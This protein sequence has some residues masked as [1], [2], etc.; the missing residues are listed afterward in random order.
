MNLPLIT[1]I[2]LLIAAAIAIVIL[3]L[4]LNKL[5]S[6]HR[7]LS[8]EHAEMKDRFR[9]IVDADAE[10][11]RVLDEA[12]ARK[13]GLQAELDAIKER[14]LGK[15]E[16]E[17]TQ[18]L[19]DIYSARETHGQVLQDLQEQQ[20]RGEIELEAIRARAREAENQALHDLKEKQAHGQ[21]ELRTL[22]ASIKQLRKE[23]EALDEEANLQSFGFYKPRYDFAASNQY[24]SKLDDIRDLQ[25]R[26]IK[27]KSA[28]VGRI[29][30]T[31]NGS[32]VEGRKQINQTLKL[33]LRAFNGESDAAI[34]KV[35]YNNVVVMETRIRKSLEAVNNLAGVQ[36]CQIAPAY[37]K[38]KLQELYLVHEYQEKVQAEKEEQRR[39]REEMREEEIAIR[40][41]E[42][43]K[44]EAER[45]ET[46]YADALRKAREEAD[47]AVGEKQQKLVGK[48]EELQRRLEEAQSNKERAIARAQMTRSGH[49]YVISNVGSFGEDVY[50]IGMTRRLDPMDRVRELGD[51]SVPFL[52]DVHAIIYSEDAPTLETKLHREFQHRRV[53]MVNE[54]KEFFR[55]SI[56][57]IAAF[58]QRNHGDIE[59]TLAAEA[60]DYRK[61]IAMMQGSQAT[62]TTQV[63]SSLVSD[64]VQELLDL[65]DGIQNNAPA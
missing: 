59:I 45:E 18:L 46:R 22:H 11:Q 60:A 62:L 17:R 49:V 27:D 55:V 26:M 48:I 13:E 8:H 1:L 39:I 5:I 58:V 57:E 41:L 32:R 42:R 16:A 65:P 44:Q 6:E 23:F 40:E 2:G 7:S 21:V 63:E 33:I 12:K 28:A 20:R 24:Q 56:D 51:A 47:R 43:A 52:F 9:N 35:K 61:T 38:L 3:L 31:V 19:N 54:R 25:K 36:Q 29:E 53:N 50:K 4:R 30:W 15:L 34:A 14:E 64:N 37:L 10:A